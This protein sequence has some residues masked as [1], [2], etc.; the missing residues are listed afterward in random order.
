[1]DTAVHR[2][3]LAPAPRKKKG[4]VWAFQKYWM[5]Y[6]LFAPV[7]LHYIVFQYIPMAGIVTA[8]QE[9]RVFRG[10]WASEWVGLKHFESFFSSIFAWRVIRNTLSINIIELI[11]GFPAPILL[12]LM[13]NEVRSNKFKRTVQ[14]ISYMPHFISTV[15][16]VG[17]IF[18]F[19][20]TRGPINE[21]LAF[22]N[23]PPLRY[24][25]NPNAFYPVFVLS[26]IWQGIGWGS[27]IYLAALTNVDPQLIEAA[28]I[29]GAGR[30]KRIWH[31]ALPAIAPTITIM[32]ILRLG[33]MMSVGTE[34]VFLMYNPALYER[35]DVIGTFVLRRGFIEGSFSFGAAVGLFNSIVNCILLIVS[36]RL[37]KL[38]GQSGLF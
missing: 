10:V 8:F 20:G 17:L 5:L 24:A 22:F 36:D 4:I 29:D 16:I 18:T 28:T 1:M 23:L 34:K 38:F 30:F 21:A 25:S 27:I 3:G 15:V 12:A 33:S 2:P 31:I 13:L 26:G 14:T 6:A 7:L 37:S 9:Y 32:L 35:A 11:F 19:V